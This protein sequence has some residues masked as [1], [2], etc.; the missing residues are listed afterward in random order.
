MFNLS[1]FDDISYLNTLLLPILQNTN[2]DLTLAKLFV[3]NKALDI[4][5]LYF[6]FIRSILI[7]PRQYDY[8]ELSEPIIKIMKKESVSNIL[9]SIITEVDV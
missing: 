6:V 2:F 5:T 9:F 7:N 8:I 3:K 4:D 1:R